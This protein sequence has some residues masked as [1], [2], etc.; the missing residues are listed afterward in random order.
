MFPDL[1]EISAQ[2]FAKS[3]KISIPN[4]YDDK[5]AHY[6]VHEGPTSYSKSIANFRNELENKEF[7]EPGKR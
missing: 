5:S 1:N 6:L 7:D 4:F 2:S 3:I